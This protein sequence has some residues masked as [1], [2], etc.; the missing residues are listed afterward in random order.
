MFNKG[1]ERTSSQTLVAR[2]MVKESLP[3]G[4]RE[5][6]NEGPADSRRQIIGVCRKLKPLSIIYINEIIDTYVNAARGAFTIANLKSVPKDLSDIV[7]KSVLKRM[8]SAYLTSTNP[9]HI[10][11]KKLKEQ[12]V[13]ALE[14]D[15][16]IK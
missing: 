15:N 16:H 10:D 3:A 5:D 8:V 7:Q 9:K 13:L 14:A 4:C 1:R 6:R 2:E 12:A 11:Y